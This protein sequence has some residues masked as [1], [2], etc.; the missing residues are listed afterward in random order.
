MEFYEHYDGAMFERDSRFQNIS[1]SDG[2]F[3]DFIDNLYYPSP[4][5]FDAIP[6][7]VIARIYEDFLSKYL[8][9]QGDY[10]CHRR[11]KNG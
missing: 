5:K 9:V 11:I 7:K 4:Y 6:V 8:A 2:V 3:T 1:L 10:I